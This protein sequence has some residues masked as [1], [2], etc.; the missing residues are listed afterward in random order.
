MTRD[1]QAITM[2]RTSDVAWL[3]GIH[4]NTVRSWANHGIIKAYR[5]S[6]RDE[7]R[8]RRQDIAHLLSKLGA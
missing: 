7:Q 8:F 3:L 2:L 6:D 5:T 4:S 1:I